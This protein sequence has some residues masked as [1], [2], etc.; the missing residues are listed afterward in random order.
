MDGPWLTTTYMKLRVENFLFY[1]RTLLLVKL[2]KKNKMGALGRG[3]FKNNNKIF[4]PHRHDISC[5]MIKICRRWGFASSFLLHKWLDVNWLVVCSNSA[6]KKI[7]S[8]LGL[9][10]NDLCSSCVLKIVSLPSKS[11]FCFLKSWIGSS[12]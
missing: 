3:V 8:L 10:L 1:H 4:S 7:K 2:F 12:R 9:W 5:W 6:W 11:S